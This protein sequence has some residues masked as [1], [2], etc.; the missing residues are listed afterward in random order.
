MIHFILGGLPPSSN[1]A[2]FT[3]VQRKGGKSIPLR[4]LTAEGKRYKSGVKTHLA[5]TR[6][7]VLGFFKP[8]KPYC[9]LVQ[10]HMSGLLT[11]TWGQPEGAASRYKKVDVSNR[12]KLLEDA[13]T[14]A[15]GHDDSQHFR[16]LLW[17]EFA[18]SPEH[19]RT[20]IWAWCWEE[21]DCPFDDTDRHARALLQRKPQ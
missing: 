11:T 4:I 8:N 16:V 17:K 7:D 1:H 12:L 13:L 2:Y 15:C 3:K 9:L 14:D 20:E 6:Q 21:E 5:Q 19:E 10:F 18:P